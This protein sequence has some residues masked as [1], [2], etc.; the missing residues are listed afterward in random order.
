MISSN[1]LFSDIKNNLAASCCAGDA[2]DLILKVENIINKDISIISADFESVGIIWPWI[3]KKDM[4]LFAKFVIENDFNISNLARDINTV[5][6]KGANGAQVFVPVQNL[7]DFIDQ[8]APIYSDLFFNKNLLI[9]LDLGHV[10]VMD[11]E[12]IFIN[13]SKIGGAGLSLSFDKSQDTDFVGAVYGFIN[14]LPDDF[15]MDLH[16]MLG[17]RPDKMEQVFRLFDKVRPNILNKIKLFLDF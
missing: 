10:L 13:L 15:D 5:L 16:F 7:T 6:K 11:W 1:S 2:S 3:E 12:N 17:N 8:F 9:G 4:N 14:A